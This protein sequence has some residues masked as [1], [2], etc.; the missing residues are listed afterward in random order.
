MANFKTHITASSVLGVGYGAAAWWLY[1]TPVPTCLLAGGLCGVGGMLPDIDSDS[2]VPLRESLAFGAA[3]VPMML[4]GRLLHAGWPHESIVL[5]GAATY[6]FIR[7][8]VG[9]L[10]KKYTVHRG[11]F[12][13]LPAAAICAELT[14]LLSAGEDEWVRYYKAIAVAVGYL[15]HLVLDELFSF[16]IKHG[17]FRLKSSFGTAI[18]VIGDNWWANASTY[19]KLAVATLLVMQDPSC[20]PNNLA[21]QGNGAQVTE[22]RLPGTEEKGQEPAVTGQAAGNKEQATGA[23]TSAPLTG[24]RRILN[25]H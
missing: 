13:S 15:S 16:Q 14:F 7:F 12:H 4:T 10:L 1:G 24:L 11:M 9:W 17:R 22:H 19:G 3:V 8:V 5:A 25:H 6:L 18:K 21:E 20:T 2:G 23:K